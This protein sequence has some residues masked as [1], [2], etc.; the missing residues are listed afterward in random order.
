MAGSG[1]FTFRHVACRA[2]QGRGA[3]MCDEVE[4]EEDRDVRVRSVTIDSG[5][6]FNDAVLSNEDRRDKWCRI[7]V[8][9]NPSSAQRVKDAVRA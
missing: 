6:E 2:K 9:G 3:A 4:M 7:S 5:L 8:F 1:S